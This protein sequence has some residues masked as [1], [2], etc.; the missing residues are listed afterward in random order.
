MIERIVINTMIEKLVINIG[1]LYFILNSVSSE[2][3]HPAQP[4]RSLVL[5]REFPEIDIT[6]KEYWDLTLSWE[7]DELKDKIDDISAQEFETTLEDFQ[8]RIGRSTLS[9]Y[10]FNVRMRQF[11]WFFG[12]KTDVRDFEEKL[13]VLIRANERFK[14][15]LKNEKAMSICLEGEVIQLE[16]IFRGYRILVD[17]EHCFDALLY[18]KPYVSPSSFLV[19]L[20]HLKKIL[21]DEQVVPFAKYP[22]YQT[23]VQQLGNE[24]EEISR[25]NSLEYQEPPK[26]ELKVTEKQRRP[27]PSVRV[28]A[29]SLLQ[30]LIYS[31]NYQVEN[32][33]ALLVNFLVLTNIATIAALPSKSLEQKNSERQPS[34][35]RVNRGT[36]QHAKRFT[37]IGA[38]FQIGTNPGTVPA[39]TPWGSQNFQTVWIDSATS[40]GIGNFLSGVN[41]ATIGS[42]PIINMPIN[43]TLATKGPTQG[44][45]VA[46]THEV[47]PGN[48]TLSGFIVDTLGNP[49]PPKDLLTDLTS[50]YVSISKRPTGAGTSVV[51]GEYT[52]GPGS[53]GIKMGYVDQT[54]GKV[55]ETT[56][57]PVL[58]GN[59]I[60]PSA[61]IMETGE[62]AV[63]WKGPTGIEGRIFVDS[64]LPSTNFFT[65]DSSSS[66]LNLPNIVGTLDGFDM[67]W[68]DQT[69]NAT[70][71]QSFAFS[72]AP[73]VSKRTMGTSTNTP[74]I[75]PLAIRTTKGG[76]FFF[77]QDCGPTGGSIA[78]QPTDMDHQLIGSSTNFATLTQCG[79]MA[80]AASTSDLLV[81]WDDVD[82]Y[83]AGIGL[84]ANATNLNAAI[85][86]NPGVPKILPTLYIQAPSYNTG[87]YTV[88]FTLTS[89]TVGNFTLAQASGVTITNGATS[90][91]VSGLLSDLN[92]AFANGITYNS[93]DG[94]FSFGANLVIVD[95]TGLSD[96]LR[97]TWNLTPATTPPAPAT[98]TSSPPTTTTSSPPAS[99]G[100]T[101]PPKSKSKFPVIPVA[102]SVGVVGAVALGV[103]GFCI[104]KQCFFSPSNAGK[105]REETDKRRLFAYALCNELK[106]PNE[107]Q[108]FDKGDHGK[109]FFTTVELIVS[110]LGEGNYPINI[111]QKTLQEIQEIAHE[112]A[113][114]INAMTEPQIMTKNSGKNSLALGE[115]RT[116]HQDIA[117]KVYENISS[118]SR[119]LLNQSV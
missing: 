21:A 50:P 80:A 37:N 57:N 2:P 87:N 112:F 72:G 74:T 6:D 101:E 35:F 96:T 17:E 40:T 12:N 43:S 41:G 1:T 11:G 28:L 76:G 111:E 47:A 3:P 100:T 106:L 8:S 61:E 55:C 65:L 75:R 64:C 79:D 92:P 36:R 70:F 52:D 118:Q 62:V 20:H 82:I 102:V 5:P 108:D 19:A 13:Q 63:V 24:I 60:K 58:T 98:T 44:S 56:A 113:T 99:T 27:V 42:A 45:I 16:A 10:D 97:G 54:L 23:L 31:F 78:T 7:L 48:F 115:F 77:W 110:K 84:N 107:Y 51:A 46:W 83:A 34:N 38:P 67:I 86:F 85:T 119:N 73:L 91:T 117:K 15:L 32:P 95:Q 4:L 88:T 33:G 66:S 93:P 14:N 94:N 18:L 103:G 22:F 104:A 116:A 9:P 90:L 81:T 53:T 68:V 26:E 30:S 39:V 29:K 105:K 89:G 71:S 59:Q 25:N 69:S 114:V 109:S 49:S